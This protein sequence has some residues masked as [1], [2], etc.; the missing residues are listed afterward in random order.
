MVCVN[1]YFNNIELFYYFRSLGVT[2]YEMSTLEH[3][4]WKDNEPFNLRKIGNNISDQP[5]I[6]LPEV[7]SRKFND[8]I[9]Q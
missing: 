1:S 9:K 8:L 7:F 3:P 2:F 6:D 5:F 4:F